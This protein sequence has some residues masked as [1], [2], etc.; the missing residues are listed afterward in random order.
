MTIYLARQLL[1][2]SCE[3]PVRDPDEDIALLLLHQ[4]GFATMPCHHGRR[5]AAV[6]WSD[7]Y[8]TRPHHFTF[9]V[10]PTSHK[11][12]GAGIVSV[13]TLRIK[14]R[15]IPLGTLSLGLPRRY[16]GIISR[17]PLATLFVEMHCCTAGVR[18]FLSP[19]LYAAGSGHLLGPMGWNIAEIYGVVNPSLCP[20]TTL[21]TS[22]PRVRGKDKLITPPIALNAIQPLSRTQERGVDGSLSGL[23]NK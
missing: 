13:A 5:N 10:W 15:V 12:M 7:E 3:R 2:E 9:H 17:L 16:V 6:R 1:A 22:L 8:R 19:K 18:T 11:A 21:R 23:K 4:R 14:L 20:S